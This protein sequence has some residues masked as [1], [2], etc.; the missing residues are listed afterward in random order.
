MA[1]Y[2]CGR[3][4]AGKCRTS[5]FQPGGTTRLKQSRRSMMTTNVAASRKIEIPVL[6]T[7]QKTR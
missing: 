2:M 4:T 1:R 3:S 5:T 7:H 6:V